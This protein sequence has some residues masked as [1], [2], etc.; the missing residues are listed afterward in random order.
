[1]AANPVLWTNEARCRDC[2]RCVR[3]CPV[4]AVE[5]KSGQ[6][7]VIIERCLLC[8]L[9]VHECPQHAKA[10]ASEINLVRQLIGN[11]GRVIASVAPS[12]PA[13]FEESEWRRLPAVLRQLGFDLVT[14]TAVGAEIISRSIAETIKAHPDQTYITTAC[15]AVVTYI[16][17]YRPETS[18]LLLPFASPMLVHARYLKKHFGPGISVVFIG[19]CLAKKDEARWDGQNGVD[20]VLTFEELRTWIEEVGLDLKAAEES[21]FD[22]VLPE[23]ARTYPLAGG[24]L[25]TSALSTNQLD[26][27]FLTVSGHDDVIEAIDS[28]AEPGPPLLL[29]ALMCPGGCLGGAGNPKKTLLNQFRTRNRFLRSIEPTPA[30]TLRKPLDGEAP[31]ISLD[32][33]NPHTLL[34]IKDPSESQIRQVLAQTGKHTTND[35]LDC[36]ACGYSTCR[37]KAV[38]VLRGMAEIEMCLPF[39]RQ[40]A[41]IQADAIV[42]NSPN[43]VVILDESL[44]IIH[45]NPQFHQMFMTSDLCRGKHISTFIDPAPFQQILDGETNQWSDIVHFRAY[46]LTCRQMIYTIGSKDQR[47]IISIL[48]NLTVSKQQEAALDRLRKEALERAEQVIDRQVEI[49]Q[50]VASLLGRSASETRLILQNLTELVQR[51]DTLQ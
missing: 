33:P 5:K 19:P 37:E 30:T 16:R 50:E 47:Q 6:A 31:N 36:G 27:S 51:K 13:A 44:K 9:C 29:E 10:Y 7:R 20:A 45:A 32:I 38:A 49:A 40:K 1:M 23:K 24:L 26:H 43:A 3:V 11:P 42:E 22:G 41:E 4:K 17:R 8:G 39:M 25:Y 15:P 28:L 46:G 34:I 2:N 12:Y 35:E 21:D 48:V 14:E 18:S